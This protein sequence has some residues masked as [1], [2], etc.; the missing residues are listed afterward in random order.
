MSYA[1]QADIDNR[2]GGELLLTIADRDGDGV[3]D[4][5]AV[6]LALSDADQLVDAH[7]VERY[8]LPLATVPDLLVAIAVDVAVYKLAS[9]PTEEQRKRYDDAL[10]LLKSIATGVLQLGLPTPPATTGQQAVFVGPERMFGRN[11]ARTW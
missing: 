11:K 4:A 3:V 2:Y 5:D 9:L 10:K 7:L 6:A 1:V 8:Q